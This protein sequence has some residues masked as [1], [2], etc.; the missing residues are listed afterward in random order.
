[1]PIYAFRCAECGHEYEE[2]VSRVGAVAAC[3]HC[4]EVK[5]VERQITT[6]ADYH[7]STKSTTVPLGCSGPS[8]G[9]DTC[10]GGTC[11]LE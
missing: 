1:M 8:C 4:G 10:C 9:L 6:P 5:K 7:G 11:G 2:L 3:P